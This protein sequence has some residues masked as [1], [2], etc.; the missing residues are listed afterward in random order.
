MSCDGYTMICSCVNV[1]HK[2][3]LSLFCE[4]HCL[5]V[6]FWVQFKVTC[7]I[8]HGIRPGYLRKYRFPVVSAY[9]VISERV[10][11]IHDE[12]YDLLASRKCAFSVANLFSI[13]SFHLSA[14]T[15]PTPT[16]KSSVWLPLSSC[17]KSLWKPSF[18]PRLGIEWLPSPWQFF[19]SVY[20]YFLYIIG[21]SFWDISL[22]DQLGIGWP[23]DPMK[24]MDKLIMTPINSND[25]VQ[26]PLKKT[27]I[28]VLSLFRTIQMMFYLSLFRIHNP[29][30]KKTKNRT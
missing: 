30:K 14:P 21:S 23:P 13:T 20:V 1:A 24:Y 25:D 8:M 16:H 10:G 12:Q 27:R 4:P 6:G 29:L 9:P 15:P 18:A 28:T 2:A 3:V 11:T 26:N 5:P 17:S 7:K 19:M 22:T